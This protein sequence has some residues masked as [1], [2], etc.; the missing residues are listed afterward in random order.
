MCGLLIL[1]SG[2]RIMGY[3]DTL[4][5]S[6][7]LLTMCITVLATMA[8]TL[9]FKTSYTTNFAQGVIS[10]MGAYT[11]GQLMFD[12]GIT[13]WVALPIGMVVGVLIGLFID[14]CVIRR[15]K[16]VTSIGKQI[17][18]MGFVSVIIGATPIIFPLDS[19]E[20]K[21]AMPLI[22]IDKQLVIGDF[23]LTYNSIVAVAITVVL[24]VAIFIMLNKSKW[25]LGVRATA[26]NEA[27]AGMMGVNT[28]AITAISWAI[29]GGV[30]TVAAVMLAWK[31]NA[32]S[33][34]FMTQVQVNA[35]LACI[36]GGFSTFYGPVLAAIILC[37]IS[38]CAGILGMIVPELSLWREAIVYIIALLIV[39]ARPQGIFGK[40]V[41]KKV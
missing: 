16:N 21:P 23:S 5:G 19:L 31:G 12:N 1:S 10:A 24:V 35:F 25:G 2:G 33:S 14:T 18:T 8:I 36:L 26:S 11:V 7:S 17:I 3:L 13:V 41:V 38:N 39:L 34:S 27:V 37:L 32:L 29:A 40:A 6:T 30:G 20:S 22:P 15:G 28:H 4:V 9:I